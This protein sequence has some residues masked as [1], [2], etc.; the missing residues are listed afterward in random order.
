MK[1]GGRTGSGHPEVVGAA[2]QRA[3]NADWSAAD[4][5]QTGSDADQTG[6]DDDQAAAALDGANAASDQQASDADQASADRFR[7]EADAEALATYET[8]RLARETATIRRRAAQASR[9][10][11]AHLRIGTA[12][13]RDD[14]AARRDQTARRRDLRA[15]ESERAIAASNAPLAEKLERLR[16][17]AAADRANAAKD[18]AY[19]ARERARLEVELLDAHL[20]D[21]TGAYRREIGTLALA[22]EIDHARRADGRFVLVF[23]DVDDLKFINDRDGHAAG[24]HV[25][26]TLVRTLRSNLRPFDPVVRYGGDEFVCGIG[27]SSLEEVE[28]RFDAIDRLLRDDLGVG[29]SVGL[30]ELAADETLDRLTARADAALL[31][32]KKRRSIQRGK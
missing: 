2:D 1:G 23:V 11:T 16:A 26:Q 31:D 29:V 32:A 28:R 10:G 27:G 6:S 8:T 24:D 9:A 3:L 25:L 14:T 15:E 13:G 17:R 12:A 4:E 20:D 22:L 7:S 30:A 21:L 18:R 5:D 19:A